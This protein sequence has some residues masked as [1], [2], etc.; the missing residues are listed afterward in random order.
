MKAAG[1][2]IQARMGSRRFPGK[3]LRDLCGK[4]LLLYLVERVTHCRL[5]D[6]V[7]V[8]TSTDD[9][10]GPIAAFCETVG[11]ECHRGALENVASR[12]LEVVDRHENWGGFVRVSGDSPLL[13]HR[14]IERAV[15][16]F[17]ADP[18]DL[19]TNVLVRTF[20]KGQSV[21]VV[22]TDAFRDAFE[23]MREPEDLEHVTR[24]F[25]EHRN[26]FTIRDFR[27]GSDHGSLQLSVDT[28][29]DLRVI[30]GIVSRMTR[31]HWSYSLEEILAMLGEGQ[32][33]PG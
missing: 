20:P 18:C 21:E 8:A 13:D 12:F 1:V 5:V 30:E 28:P 10:D 31:P 26:D 29:E 22:S 23:R 25:Y 6:G 3:V 9:S 27:A 2:I 24:Y 15:G 14:L 16:M 17:R 32:G 4:P 33:Q 11:V 19:V 7:V